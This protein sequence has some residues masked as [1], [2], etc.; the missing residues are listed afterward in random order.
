MET[1]NI[2]RQNFINEDVGQKK[3]DVL[4][5]RYNNLYPR[6]SVVSIPLYG[7]SVEYDQKI[8]KLE[9]PLD[10]DVF[11]NIDDYIQSSDIIVNLVDNEVFKRK[12][13]Y[14]IYKKTCL[15]YFNAGINLFNG[16]CYVSYP[17]FT[18]LYTLDHPSFIDDVEEV[19]VHSCADADAEGTSDN[20]E[21]M[22]NGNDM[23]ASILANLYQTS[24]ADCITHRKIKFTCGIN[25]SIEKEL[26]THASVL[27]A[28]DLS[29][30]EF[31]DD[32]CESHQ[33]LFELS[34]AAHISNLVK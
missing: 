32:I 11:F 14:V 23:A 4:S 6:I 19:K 17:V 7:T 33:K 13:D 29:R 30:S 5:E 31:P 20:P 18:N 34:K 24:I 27:F 1:K 12:I 22:F 10:S 16:Q 2:I 25:V 9:K 28:G 8:S 15:I 26:P 21:Q 3:S